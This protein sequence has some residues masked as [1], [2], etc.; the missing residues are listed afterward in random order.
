[1]AAGIHR[2][3]ALQHPLS[4]LPREAISGFGRDRP[5]RQGI[6][7]KRL[8][9][10]VTDG[11]G[12]DIGLVLLPL[13][14]LFVLSGLPLVYNVVM[15]FQEV[16]MFSLGSFWRPE[17][18]LPQGFAYPRGKIGTSFAEPVAEPTQAETRAPLSKLV[19]FVAGARST[20]A[21]APLG[22]GLRALCLPLMA[23]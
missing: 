17:S 20:L 11:S 4:F 9:S 6:V 8:L 18:H 19:N 1:M 15:S 23:V 13:A 22:T 16:D 10:S 3:T 21:S 5:R 2:R 14:F 7:M 12:F